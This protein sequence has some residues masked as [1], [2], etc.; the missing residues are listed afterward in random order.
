VKQA[1]KTVVVNTKAKLA[2]LYL[3]FNLGQDLI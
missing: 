1:I 2:S 3:K